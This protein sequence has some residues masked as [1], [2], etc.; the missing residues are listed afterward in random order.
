MIDQGFPQH[1]IGVVE[2]NLQPGAKVAVGMEKFEVGKMVG[3]KPKAGYKCA[4]CYKESDTVVFA[5]DQTVLK[6]RRVP[7]GVTYIIYE[8]HNLSISTFKTKVTA[9][10]KVSIYEKEQL[11]TV[12]QQIKILTKPEMFQCTHE[13]IIRTRKTKDK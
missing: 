12:I 11:T 13:T 6:R 7:A 4:E 1:L 9:F 5:D 8:V 2:Q 3:T 10:Y